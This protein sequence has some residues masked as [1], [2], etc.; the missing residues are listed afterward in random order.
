MVLVYIQQPN[1]NANSGPIQSSGQQ[2]DLNA[3]S[4]PASNQNEGFIQ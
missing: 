3:N 2:Q 4:G 1:L